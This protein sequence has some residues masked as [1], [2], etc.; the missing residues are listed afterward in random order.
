MKPKTLRR[1]R[2]QA[3]RTVR[4]RTIEPSDGPVVVDDS[5]APEAIFDRVTGPYGGRFA[6]DEET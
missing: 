3:P 1:A 6:T 2:L 4:R 5:S